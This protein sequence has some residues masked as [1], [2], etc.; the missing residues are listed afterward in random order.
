L[1]QDI[2]W[3]YYQNEAPESFDQSWGRQA[4]LVR[5]ARVSPRPKVLNIGVGTGIFEELALARGFD[6]YSLD[7]SP[8]SIEVL[9]S[10]LGLGEDHAK[11]G[12]SQSIPFPD[13]CFN[14][15]VMSEVLE[16]LADDVLHQT[17]GEVHRV[18]AS[19]GHF[20]GTVPAREDLDANMVI[21]PHCG[22]RFHRWGHLQRFDIARMRALLAE[23][24]EVE[25]LEERFFVTWSRLNWKGKL[26][27]FAKVALLRL[28]VHGSN[29]TL[30]FRGQKR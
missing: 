4:F 10:R 3:D 16:H 17:L 29:E 13:G 21:C 28:G 14:V 6:V 27:S 9:R 2:I 12:Y 23:R 25:E 7:P 18:L 8:H 30:Y 19:G 26:S 24:F 1:N 11:V 5:K 20:M 22:E 15:V